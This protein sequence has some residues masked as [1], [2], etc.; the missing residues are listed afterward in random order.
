MWKVLIKNE[1]PFT[2]SMAFCRCLRRDSRKKDKKSRPRTN[3]GRNL[4]KKMSKKFQVFCSLKK[5]K[6]DSIRVIFGL[7]QLWMEETHNSR[8]LELRNQLAWTLNRQ[9]CDQPR[10]TGVVPSRQLLRSNSSI[11]IQVLCTFIRFS[12]I[13]IRFGNSGHSLSFVHSLSTFSPRSWQSKSCSFSASPSNLVISLTK[14]VFRVKV[15]K[16]RKQFP[17]LRKVQNRI[18]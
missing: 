3:Y 5:V 9:L 6:Y 1:L 4:K 16:S 12:Y 10:L 8:L 13:W 15:A 14:W 18:S 11:W 2:T 7:G 17:F